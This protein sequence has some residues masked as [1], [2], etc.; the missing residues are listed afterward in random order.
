MLS[1]ISDVSIKQQCYA[2]NLLSSLSPFTELPAEIGEL[3][4]F[5][6]APHT[7]VCGR[8]A[9]TLLFP[10]QCPGCYTSHQ[11]H[12]LFISCHTRIHTHNH[13]PVVMLPAWND[14]HPVSRDICHHKPS[15]HSESPIW[16]GWC[17]VAIFLIQIRCLTGS[18]YTLQREGR[19]GCE[20]DCSC[21]QTCHNPERGGYSYA[22]ICVLTY[23]SHLS[24]KTLKTQK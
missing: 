10:S 4:T 23:P 11:S 2:N 24:H 9:H 17:R 16:I 1:S 3:P 6:F 19:G 13:T 8:S 14:G 5:I 20:W 21:C 22:Q 18:G 7:P 15:R 12:Y